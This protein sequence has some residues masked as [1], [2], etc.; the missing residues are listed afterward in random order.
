MPGRLRPCSRA[1]P[2]M[3]ATEMNG[4]QNFYLDD[5]NLRRLLGRR[6]PNLA[7]RWDQNLA[8]FGAWVC[9]E[10]DAAAAYT[11]HLAPPVVEFRDRDGS[12]QHHVIC[13]ARYETVHRQVYE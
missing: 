12:L 5:A 1:A 3:S 6:A 4:A 9:S 13:N 2:T 7:D 8:A 11:D 10:V